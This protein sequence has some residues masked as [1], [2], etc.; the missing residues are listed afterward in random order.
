MI[1]MIKMKNRVLSLLLVFISTSILG[2]NPEIIGIETK[3]MSMIFSAKPNDMVTF[4][5]WGDKMNNNT[6]F[7]NRGF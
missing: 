1:K 3:D 7:V 6:S 5:Y 4:Q 2:Q